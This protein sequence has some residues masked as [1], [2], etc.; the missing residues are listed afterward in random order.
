MPILDVLHEY[1]GGEHYGS[2][3]AVRC[4]FHGDNHPSMLVY[5]DKYSCK[6]CGAFGYTQ[7]LLKKVQG[8][9]L[10][11]FYSFGIEEPDTSLPNPFRGWLRRNSLSNVLKGAWEFANSNPHMLTYL[12]K[13]RGIP[14]STCRTLGIGTRDEFFTFPVTNPQKKIVG[15]FVRSGPGLP[16]S[17]YFVPKDQDPNLLYAPSWKRVD[18]SQVVFLTYGPIDAITLYQLGFAAISTLSGKNLDVRVLDDIRKRIVIIPDFIEDRE[19]SRMAAKLGWRGSVCNFPY[20]DG[21]K[22][23]NE[24]YKL[25]PSLI[26]ETLQEHYGDQLEGHF[27]DRLWSGIAEPA[28]RNSGA[29]GHAVSPVQ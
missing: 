7:S 10:S 16:S 11:Q 29:T 17:R 28:V 15:A 27:G 26:A 19:A 6:A 2:Y 13:D 20:P 14:A 4:P 5:E 22:D 18:Q 24:C 8:G 9:S 12:T 3:L 25:R 23:L 1:M 21:T